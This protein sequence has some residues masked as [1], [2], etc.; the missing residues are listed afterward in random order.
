MD[1]WTIFTY[2][3]YI[4]YIQYI[5]IHIYGFIY[6]NRI[7]A[8]FTITSTATRHIYAVAASPLLPGIGVARSE[9]LGSARPWT[10]RTLVGM[11]CLP[12][13]SKGVRKIF[14][15]KTTLGY[16]WIF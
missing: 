3:N 13:K 7:P 14:P 9:A 11:G 1:L 6:I 16:S 10:K 2:T 5:Y 8:I 4:I 12:S 15:E